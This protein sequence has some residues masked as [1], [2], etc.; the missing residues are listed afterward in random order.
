MRFIPLPI[1][2]LFRIEPERHEDARGFFA[3]TFCAAEFAERGLWTDFPQ[4]NISFNALK[5]TVRGMHF[6]KPPFEEVK[7]V[8]CIAGAILDVAV[9]LRP[10]SATYLSHVAIELSVD[11]R[12]ALYISAGFAHGFQALSD[13]A[14][15]SYL[16]GT[17][18]QPGAGHGL[19]WDDPA[20]D[21]N[22]PQKVTVLS[23]QDRSFPDFRP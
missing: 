3:R 9:D 5:G 13:G 6:Q 19:R 8:S 11:N 10:Q 1:Q 23:A 18:Y 2:G 17:P 12:A 14:T 7:V 21:I 16:M 20:L 22:W 15:V 4:H